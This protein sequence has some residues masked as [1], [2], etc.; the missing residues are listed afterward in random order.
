M[1]NMLVIPVPSLLSHDV[2][3]EDNAKEGPPETMLQV[4]RD[5]QRE[6]ERETVGRSLARS[7]GQASERASERMHEHA[8]V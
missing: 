4:D 5:R 1:A 7:L 8:N 3:G 6:R 2:G